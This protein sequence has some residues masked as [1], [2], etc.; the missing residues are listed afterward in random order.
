MNLNVYLLI[1]YNLIDVSYFDENIDWTYLLT[2]C[3]EV[4]KKKYVYT[5]VI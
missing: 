3:M 2:I 5:Y 1:V 4:I